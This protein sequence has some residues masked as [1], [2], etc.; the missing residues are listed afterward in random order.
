MSFST[1]RQLH[2]LWAC[3][4]PTHCAAASRVCPCML[5][6]TSREQEDREER[7]RLR[8]EGKP[9]PPELLR[10]GVC[11]FACA[12]VCVCP[13]MCH[14]VGHS[15]NIWQP[16]AAAKA[17]T[18]AV[19]DHCQDSKALSWLL[20]ASCCPTTI[21]A[22]IHSVTPPWCCWK[23]RMGEFELTRSC[24]CCCRRGYGQRGWLWWW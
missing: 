19:S 12:C 13:C 9:L 8:K 5:L 11:T 3:A 20:A 14:S 10:E 2:W 23:A 4:L 22:S 6:C 17:A 21:E 1:S 15:L 16:V 7:E 18:A 24:A